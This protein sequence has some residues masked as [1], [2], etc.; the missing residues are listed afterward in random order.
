MLPS[1]NRLRSGYLKIYKDKKSVSNKYFLLFY[2]ENNTNYSK[3]GFVIRKKVGK[4]FFRNKIKRR[5][6][7]AIRENLENISPGFD[8]IFL[9][10]HNFTDWEQVSFEEI[11]NNIFE[12]LK[13]INKI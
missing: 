5:F 6:R 2:K 9:I 8:F 10:N 13:S 1:K 11:K 3:F 12:T 7:F 4:A